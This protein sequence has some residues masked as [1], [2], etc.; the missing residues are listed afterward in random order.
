[1]FMFKGV[2]VGAKLYS[3]V[4]FLLVL[5]IFVGFIGL[6]SANQ[7]KLSLNTVYN[8]RV[9]PLKDLK[10]ISD[11]YAVNIVDASHKVN[12]GNIKWDQG[13]DSVLNAVKTIK[14]KW[15]A[16]LETSLVEEEIKIINEAKPLILQA[17]DSIA[18]LAKI[19]AAKDK[20]GLEQFVIS[21]LYQAIDP[22]SGKFGELV[23]I[24]LVVAKSEYDSALETY[25]TSKRIS[26]AI[27]LLAVFLGLFF[28]VLIVRSVTIPVLQAGE[29]AK[30]MAQGDFTSSLTSDKGDEIGEMIRAM[31]TMAERLRAMI[32]TIMNGVQDLSAKSAELASISRQLSASSSDT[33]QKSASVA[34]AA[35]EMNTNIQSVSAA[36]EQSTGNI[37]MVAS[38]AEE[39]SATIA[40]IGQNAANAQDISD[41]AVS[42]SNQ[43]AD[44]IKE[45]IQ[46]SANVSRVTT[47]I[48][49]VSEQTNLLALN[50]TIEA[51]RAGDAGKGFA[52]VANEIKE[53]A[54]QT[55]VATV[56]IRKQ[57]DEM[58]FITNATIEDISSI[59]H[60]IRDINL[61]INGIASSV[62][63]QSV[64]TSDIS[65][66]I[67]QAAQGVSE[68]NSST[69]NSSVVVAEIARDI[70]MISS[71]SSQVETASHEVEKNA[72]SLSELADH[73]SS[74]V[75][76]FKVN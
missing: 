51:A 32:K 59:A 29:I 19:L 36:M 69:A 24:Q 33:A 64:A 55:A 12:S 26:V 48:T 57:I 52:V 65:N 44:K 17:D 31:G 41:K 63:E 50:A 22:V 47:V 54:R 75:N 72:A 16:Y 74:L 39:M 20:E 34:T 15:D 21:K 37:S 68:V 70:N 67:V 38:A 28:G 9:V 53:L 71:E 14:E 25:E 42:H 73:L 13:L 62:E 7:S 60:V 76:Q 3:L 11:M 66:N 49:E 1:M 56:E 27:I 61:S 2:K 43:T 10:V 46:A 4:I 18:D 5:F 45:L 40:E 8:D 30:A 35:E 23:D 6:Y 58:Q